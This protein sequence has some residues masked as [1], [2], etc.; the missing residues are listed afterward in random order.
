MRMNSLKDMQCI[1]PTRQSGTAALNNVG[2]VI[3]NFKRSWAENEGRRAKVGGWV[4]GC[5]CGCGW[6]GG[7]GGGGGSLLWRVERL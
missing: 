2:E 4:G 1:V 7:G 6:V 3:A 5:G